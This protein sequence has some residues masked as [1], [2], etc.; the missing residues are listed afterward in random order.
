MPL[1][2]ACFI[3]YRGYEGNQLTETLVNGLY[4]SL[5]DELDYYVGQNRVYRDKRGGM[6]PGSFLTPNLSRAL[7]ESACLVVVYG[8]D[9]FSRNPTWCA[10]EFKGMLDLEAQRL[11]A[12]PQSEHAN[13]LLIIIVFRGKETLPAVFTNNRLV[14]FFDKYALY[15]PEIPRNPDL[16]PQIVTIAQYIADR[17][18]AL[19]KLNPDPCAICPGFSLPSEAQ[20]LT[21][22]DDL[23]KKTGTEIQEQPADAFPR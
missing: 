4:Q 19:I 7:C 12:L 11:K 18:K 2:Y 15:Q 8:P 9:Y 20:V 16:Y 6:A 5:S 17:F 14:A 13:G 22:L 23:E 3:S 10:Q 21:W 1:K